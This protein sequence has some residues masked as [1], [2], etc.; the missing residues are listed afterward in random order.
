MTNNKNTPRKSELYLS[1]SQNYTYQKL[2][3]PLLSKVNRF[4]SKVDEHI[5]TFPHFHPFLI[6]G[7][8][9]FRK[10]IK[11]FKMYQGILIA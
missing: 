9:L 11:N 7:K 5:D 3:I 6:L 4:I 2:I 1:K 8:V 10:F